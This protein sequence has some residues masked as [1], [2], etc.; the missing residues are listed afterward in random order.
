MKKFLIIIFLA[1]IISFLAQVISKAQEPPGQPKPITT[2]KTTVPNT[3]PI[4]ID[5]GLG[6]LLAAGVAYAGKKLYNTK[7]NK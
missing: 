4:P 6:F 2:V 7:E 3:V 5:G 1:L